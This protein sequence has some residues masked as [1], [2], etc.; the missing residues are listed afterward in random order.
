MD[1]RDFLR[2]AALAGV[3]VYAS[4]GRGAS[5]GPLE[6]DLSPYQGPFWVSI[7]V[8]G[9]W[10]P[11]LL[12]DPKG[13]ETGISKLYNES[14]IL[15]V[16]GLR[17][18][19]VGSNAYFFKKYASRLCV[20]NGIDTATGTHDAGPAHVWSGT[21]RGGWP[22]FSAVAAASLGPL[23]PLSFISNGGYDQTAGVVAKSVGNIAAVAGDPNIKD[24]GGATFHSPATMNRIRGAQQA[25]L[26]ALRTRQSLPALRRAAGELYAARLTSA[27]LG[28][29]SATLPAT[30]SDNAL[31]RQAQLAFAAYKAGLAVSA[32][33]IADVNVDT[34]TNH[35]VVH[36]AELTKAI[37]AIDLVIAEAEAFGIADAL[38]L[39]IGSDFGRGPSYNAQ[40]GKDHYSIT[41]MMFMGPGIPKGRV[42]GGTDDEGKP[43]KVNPSTLERDDKAGVRITPAHIHK[44]LRAKAGVLGT[45]VDKAFPVF[46]SED[47]PLF[48]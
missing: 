35:D 45:G 3:A 8:P 19:P 37:D 10:D 5:A 26:D 43:F 14:S 41:S 7:H 25:R 18:A 47:M 6:A 42:I 20:I 2:L 24:G 17:C 31:V 16:G 33:L 40:N 38:V 9:G 39:S 15:E 27:E 12:C 28:K 34:H 48:G 1:R 30:L 32:T 44:A 13:S 36:V 21:L 46:V 4:G 22:C 23:R 11:A 29:L